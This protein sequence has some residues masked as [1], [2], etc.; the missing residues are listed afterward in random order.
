MFDYFFPLRSLTFSRHRALALGV[1]SVLCVPS[2]W[3]NT[4]AAQSEA[5]AASTLPSFSVFEY[6]VDGNSL[7]PDGAIENAVSPFMGEGK[8][9]RDVES[10]RAALEKA[11]HDAGYL[12]VLVSIPEQSVDT[13]EVA[14]HV[15]E[16]TID[17]LKI[18]GAEYTLP[19]EIRARV[20]ELAEGKVPNFNT[21][22]TQLTALNRVADAKV[23]PILRAGREPGTVEVQLDVEDQLPLHGSVEYSNRQ[24][25][26]TT[27]QR[28]SASM[29]Y[30]NLW[31]RRHSFGLTAQVAPQRTSDVSV[32]AGTY[33]LPVD[34]KGDSLTLY[35]VHSRSQFATLAGAPG[36][37]LLG[38]SDTLGARVS[39][40]LNSTADYTQSFS[41]GLDYKDI[42]QTLIATGG[43]GSNS[44]ITYA[45][46]VASYTA[47]LFGQNRSSTVDLSATSG[48]R[49]FLGNNDAKFNAKRAG[50]AANFLALR[51]GLQHTESI[52]R[53][54]LYGKLDMQ[55]SSTLL[56]PTEQFVAGGAESVRGYLE[57][58][59]AGDSG[60]RASME[61]RTP[62]MSFGS[63]SALWRVSG[64]AFLDVARLSIRQAVFPQAATQRLSGTGFGVRLTAPRGFSIEMDAAR[65]LLDG[66]LTRAGKTRIHART[67]WAF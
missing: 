12:T 45:P 33:V 19:S 46:L 17:R 47:N 37:G 18:K 51:A 11:Y 7:L 58:E 41:I 63:Q 52:S 48:L 36:L 23:T 10:A 67:L 4:L 66:D 61:L 50:A 65:A 43:V 27:A 34:D 25:P 44:P 42:K 39:V 14:L 22:Q 8:T 38:S 56:V 21:M 28:L 55:L 5:A 40:P 64:L 1:M 9:L 16:A 26:N 59:R 53:W 54:A 62:S 15:V 24:T 49:G 13:G 29:R 30:D 3:A 6:A 57:G 20:P 2:A 60:L 32:L 35:A 31:Q